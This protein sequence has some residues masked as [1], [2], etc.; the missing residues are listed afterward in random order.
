MA[1][2]QWKWTRKT[3]IERSELFM[4]FCD[5]TLSY[6][7]A[8]GGIRTYIDN[9]RR[10]I[11]DHT[12]H[13]HLLIVPGE[14]DEVEYADGLTTYYVPSP[15]IPGHAPYRT[16]WRP[17][18]IAEVLNR[19]RPDVIE[20]GSYYVSAW[21]AF[22]YRD[23]QQKAGH[24][25]TVGAYFHTDVAKAFV[26]GPMESAISEGVGHWSETLE[27]IGFQL[28][29]LVSS[30]V[31]SY[32]QGVFD[33]CDLCMA[34]S[35]QQAQRLQ[36]YG[37]NGVQVIPL[38][39]NLELFHPDKRNLLVRSEL[40]LPDDACVLIYG[41]RLNEEK[42]VMTLVEVLK[43]LPENFHLLLVGEGPMRDGLEQEAN[44][45]GRM[46]VLPFERDPEKYAALIASS[47]IYVTAGPF[48]TFGLS[49]AEAQAAGMPVVGVA[50]GALT[51]RVNETNG[52]LGP[53]DDAAAFAENVRYVFAHH[54]Q[55]S[56]AAR[57]HA[58]EHYSWNSSFRKAIQLYEQTE[59]ARQL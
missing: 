22:A 43:L 25:V 36:E 24:A 39:V 11:R 12:P 16:F 10:Y 23:R 9:K 18:P 55:F 58:E 34:A 7:Q 40:N 13:D 44:R 21:S 19:T 20:L 48:E 59:L 14:C 42:H 4:L 27:T 33:R 30:G 46:Q 6:N 57:S 5:I 17:G 35:P 26:S 32:I 49:I 53:V 45:I 8:S 51:Q 37:I 38:G 41:G 1:R 3:G 54:S 2:R 31:E 47:D 52:R 29:N 15:L 28:T 56:A 50:E